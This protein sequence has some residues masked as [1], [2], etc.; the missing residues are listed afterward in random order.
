MTK[1]KQP[2]QVKVSDDKPVIKPLNKEALTKE[3]LQKIEVSDRKFVTDDRP[4]NNFTDLM[5]WTKQVFSSALANPTSLNNY[6]SNRIVIDG[7]FMEFATEN[8]LTI[9]CLYKDSIISWNTEDNYEKFFVQGV[10]LI[11]SKDVEFIHAA[12]FHKGTSFE[13]EI[14][15][16]VIASNSNYD[17]YVRLRNEHD[18]WAK[19]RDRNNLYIRVIAG[20]DIPYTKDLTWD[21]VFLPAPMKND[22]KS[23]VETFLISKDFYAANKMPWKRGAILHG[24][25][26]NGKSSLIKVIMSQYDF[27]P[28]SIAP[29]ANTEAMYESF[30]YASEQSPALLFFEDL[31]SM[32]DRTVDTSSFLNLMDGVSSKNGLLVIAT[33][34]NIKALKTS[35]T[36]RPSRFDRKFEI[37]GP[38]QEMVD[39]YLRKWFGNTLT[40]AKY[41]DLAK[42]AEKYEFSY[43]YLKELY[44][45]SMYEA[46]SH[47]R[48]VPTEKDI[49]ASLNKL[50]KDKQI[51]GGNKI[52]TEK[53][54]NK[55]QG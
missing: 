17:A 21:D 20:D 24:F 53:Y 18:V 39:I 9:E 13:D 15:F 44:I 31:D 1:K 4:K 37:P 47:N 26:G 40:P 54:F 6:V 23:M 42:A 22:I 36:D 12:L 19:K 25:P 48:K 45:S 16:F 10:F 38:N 51:F 8:N 27:K 3:I 49:D 50:I 14:S 41:K 5:N 30:R 32:L 35:I 34:N 2:A 7:L 28:V 29:G 43:A 11:K 33:A 52:N 55:G 46:I